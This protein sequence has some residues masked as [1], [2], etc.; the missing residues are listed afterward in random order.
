MRE[1]ECEKKEGGGGGGRD[2]EE[3][4][5]WG[6]RMMWMRLWLDNFSVVFNLSNA[7]VEMDGDRRGCT[8]REEGYEQREG[9][10]GGGGGESD[11]SGLLVIKQGCHP[12]QLHMARPVATHQMTFINI[13]ECSKPHTDLEPIKIFFMRVSIHGMFNSIMMTT[14]A[15]TICL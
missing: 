2:G 5:G 12:I 14:F 11:E 4:E 8:M 10:G 7:G 9:G 15:H 13:V 3:R 1:E 6:G